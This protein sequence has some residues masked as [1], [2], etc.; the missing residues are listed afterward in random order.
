MAELK[1]GGTSIISDVSGT[2]RISAGFPAGHVIQT[3][4]KHHDVASFVLATTTSTFLD[5]S[6]A[7]EKAIT[8]TGT[9]KV[10]V[11]MMFNTSYNGSMAFYGLV[12]D[13]T[14]IAKPDLTDRT[15]TPLLYPFAISREGHETSDAGMYGIQTVQRSV[16]YLDSPGSAGTYTYK[17]RANQSA[18]YTGTIYLN[19]V[20]DDNVGLVYKPITISTIVLQEIAV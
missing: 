14:V 13:S 6:P 8:I 7:F 9:N 15:Y 10:L 4:T 3:V 17:L 5:F 1:L 12:R 11:S 2:A 18:Q 19:R 16:I 20:V